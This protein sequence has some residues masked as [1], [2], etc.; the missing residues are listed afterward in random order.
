MQVFLTKED[1]SRSHRITLD[2]VAGDVVRM[3]QEVMAVQFVEPGEHIGRGAD[4]IDLVPQQQR[5]FPPFELPVL[6]LMMT[7][8]NRL[9][10]PRTARM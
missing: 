7:S 2:V 3:P 9:F 1:R 5:P 4:D 6:R 10:L 8:R